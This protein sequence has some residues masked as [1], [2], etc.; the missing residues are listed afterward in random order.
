MST[1]LLEAYGEV[2]R[3]EGSVVPIDAGH[4]RWFVTLPEREMAG[5]IRAI[6]LDRA[7]EI[8][9]WVFAT[10]RTKST[11]D[12][13]QLIEA[14]LYLVACGFLELGADGAARSV[15]PEGPAPTPAEETA[16]R[17]RIRVSQWLVRD[18]FYSILA[19]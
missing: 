18:V 2:C 9:S 19:E 8:H 13:F 17:R 4:Y 7:D 16:I 1:E 5:L 3:Q 14:C 11:E 15:L 10:P 6:I 12:I